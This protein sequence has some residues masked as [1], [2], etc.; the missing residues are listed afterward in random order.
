[1]TSG[2]E[3][4]AAVRHGEKAKKGPV[5]AY[6]GRDSSRVAHGGPR[7]GLI[8][9]KAVGNA[10]VRHR[11]A[12]R[13]RH[14]FLELL[15]SRPELLEQGDLVVIR[16]LPYLD[17]VTPDDLAQCVESAIQRAVGQFRNRQQLSAREQTQ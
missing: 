10:V 1:M 14:M 3:F 6:V 13:L 11:S 12:R 2:R 15:R 16:A 8:I 9:N 5:V 4:S 17:S 7:L